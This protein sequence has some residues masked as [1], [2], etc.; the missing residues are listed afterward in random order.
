MNSETAPKVPAVPRV[1]VILVSY[2]TRDLLR[3]ALTR[4]SGDVNVAEIWVVDNASSDGSAEMVRAEFPGVGLIENTVN[5]GFG[6][7]NNQALDRATGDL[8][9]LI[10]SDAFPEPGAIGR[11][12]QTFLDPSVAAAGGRLTFPDGRLQESACAPLTLWAIVCEQLWLE[13]AFPR[14]R[15]LSPYWQSGRLAAQGPGPHPV[16]QVMGACL[17]MR[18]GLRFDERFFL[19]VEDTELCHRLRQRGQ[20]LFVPEAVFV[21]DLGASSAG[22]RWESVARYNRGK[23]LYLSIHGGSFAA[24]MAWG[25]NRLGA[26]LRLLLYGLIALATLG[27]RG[28]ES[29]R[30]W[31]R[32]LTAPRLG[33][34]EPPGA[35]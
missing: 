2:N 6:R 29:V 1:S 34:P 15:W 22:T 25:L 23:E 24:G 4:L 28:R 31:V 11:L 13:K 32:V 17:M 12:A 27:R 18:P 10:N 26:F 19:Y 5:R 16:A 33:P 30:L 7:A 21:H 35:A 14:S 3:R 20:I 9:L 8:I